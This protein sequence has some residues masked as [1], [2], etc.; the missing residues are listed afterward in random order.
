MY[1]SLHHASRDTPSFELMISRPLV[2]F[3]LLL[4]VGSATSCSEDPVGPEPDINPD[5]VLL[6]DCC[7]DGSGANLWMGTW[8]GDLIY[9]TKAV[10]L[11]RV[12]EDL[13]VVQDSLI[14]SLRRSDGRPI[15]FVRAGGVEPALL[16]VRSFFPDVSAGSLHAYDPATSA[17]RELLDSTRTVSSA[18]YVPRGPIGGPGRVIYYSYGDLARY[19]GPA[20]GSGTPGYYLYDAED[21]TDALLVAHETALGPREVVN[22]F[23]VSPDGR[24]LLYPLHFEGRTPLLVERDLITGDADTLDVSFE[25]QL[26]WV[27]AHP[28]RSGTVLYGNYPEGAGGM[29]VVDFSE[30]GVLDLGTGTRR[31]LDT[32]TE[33]IGRSLDVFPTWS[34]DGRHV[35]YGSGPLDEERG[36][37]GRYSLYAF[38][39]VF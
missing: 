18:A 20:L 26:L 4:V 8:V 24:V 15:N 2:L 35:L 3:L 27:R 33:S 30:V 16:F 6:K 7:R 14:E 36:E 11:L 32:N 22:G 25:R 38:E 34:P 1:V 19:G 13:G 21:G 29:A 31:V 12:D 9:A 39:G 23:D 37:R 28:T 5:V 17:D 10:Y